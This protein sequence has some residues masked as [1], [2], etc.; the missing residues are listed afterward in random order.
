MNLFRAASVN[1]SIKPTLNGA[2]KVYYM[3]YFWGYTSA[4]VVYCV[5]C[6]FWPE[7][8]TMIAAIIYSDGELVDGRSEE[9]SL[10]MPEKKA[11]GVHETKV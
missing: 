11:T 7:K 10:D 6:H 9:R 2:E 4:F 1:P 3:F 5:L 8:D